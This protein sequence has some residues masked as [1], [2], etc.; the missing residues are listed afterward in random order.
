MTQG[1]NPSPNPAS[2]EQPPVIRVARQVSDEEREVWEMADGRGGYYEHGGK[3]WLVKKSRGRKCGQEHGGASGLKYSYNVVEAGKLGT[4]K[5]RE[6]REKREREQVTKSS[7]STFTSSSALSS[8]VVDPFPFLFLHR[9]SL[10][11]RVSAAL[12]LLPRPQASF[13]LPAAHSRCSR[14]NR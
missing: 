2:V 12:A 8:F 11:R 10:F 7:S 1:E 3:V 5:Q 4:V 6:A 9:R 13:S 14:R